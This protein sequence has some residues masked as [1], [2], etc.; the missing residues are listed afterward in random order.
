M[1]KQVEF[2][3][4]FGSPT[5]YLA[6]TQLPKIAT[7]KNAEILWTPIL[8]GGVHKG[9][10]NQSP[11]FVPAKSRWMGKDMQIWAKKYGVQLN[12]NP[13]FPINTI[14][15][16]RAAIG[17][18][19]KMN[20]Q[21]VKFVDTVYKAFWIDQKNLGD[22]DV[23]REVLDKGEFDSNA[24]FSL[25]GDQAVKDRLKENSEDAVNRGVFGAPTFFVG[26]DMFFG[27]DRLHFVADA[28]DSL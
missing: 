21:F 2:L 10:G 24:I 20:N 13:N 14:S 11:A 16:M 15:L 17:I 5:A 1:S 23:V 6:Y 12:S 28:I 7:D 22:L 18:Q 27:Q 8:L 3:F 9:S 26:D 19:M 25:V 4:D